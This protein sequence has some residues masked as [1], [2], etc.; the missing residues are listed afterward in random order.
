MLPTFV[1]EFHRKTIIYSGIR[2]AS[3]LLKHT[4]RL[5]AVSDVRETRH[6]IMCRRTCHRTVEES[7]PSWKDL[8]R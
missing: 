5:L 6:N 2:R 8:S 7:C 3:S 1:G 4:A